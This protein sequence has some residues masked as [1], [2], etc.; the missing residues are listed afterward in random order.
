[1]RRIVA[2]SILGASAGAPEGSWVGEGVRNEIGQL[3][4]ALGGLVCRG[5]RVT[6]ICMQGGR[7][8]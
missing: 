6:G 1:M 7:R 2:S 8:A 3:I 4:C 5:T